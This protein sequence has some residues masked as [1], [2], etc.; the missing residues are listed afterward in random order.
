MHKKLNQPKDLN[1]PNAI[2]SSMQH[3]TFFDATRVP[4][5]GAKLPNVEDVQSKKQNIISDNILTNYNY[6]EEALNLEKLTLS[7][8]NDKLE[9]TVENLQGI[10][11]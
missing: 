10:F 3:R 6:F 9:P 2:I 7:T 8:Q 5:F 1:K 4:K 11:S